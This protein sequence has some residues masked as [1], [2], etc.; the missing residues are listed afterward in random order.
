MKNVLESKEFWKTMR[1][2]LSDKNTV[3]S[4]IIIEKKQ[5]K[6]CL[7]TSICLKSLALSLKIPLGRSMYII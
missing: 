1:P 7:M 3:F 4:L 6:L 2:F 5:N